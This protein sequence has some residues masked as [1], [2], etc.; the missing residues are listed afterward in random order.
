[1]DEAVKNHKH[2]KRNDSQCTFGV[3]L[4]DIINLSGLFRVS[5]PE[6]T[7]GEGTLGMIPEPLNLA[8]PRQSSFRGTVIF[9][10][11]SRADF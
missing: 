8:S 11:T 7:W 1:M 4:T 5:P 9:L 3:P 6:D 2:Q 10:L